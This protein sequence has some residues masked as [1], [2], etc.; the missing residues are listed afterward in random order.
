MAIRRHGLPD[1]MGESG[2]TYSPTTFIP[3]QR[4]QTSGDTLAN[5]AQG[6]HRITPS[7]PVS[8][9][10]RLKNLRYENPSAVWTIN[11]EGP[12]YIPR[13]P[14][15]PQ[16]QVFM[17]NINGFT[18]QP[19]FLSPLTSMQIQNQETWYNRLRMWVLGSSI[20]N[21]TSTPAQIMFPSAFAIQE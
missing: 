6:I 13:V 19:R 3:Y 11:P 12:A 2:N 4:I 14:G 15:L 16:Q 21:T 1:V 7:R 5:R 9:Q 17:A 18:A 20:D 10:T 8:A